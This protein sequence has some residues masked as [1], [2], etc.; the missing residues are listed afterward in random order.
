[1]LEAFITNCGTYASGDF[2]GEY[3]KFPATQKD[4]Q[5]LL[6]RIGVDGVLHEE[7]FITDYVTDIAGIARSLGEYE[8]IDELNYLAAL[9]DELD[10]D[11]M[12]VFEAAVE[13]GEH[14]GSVENLINLAQNLE[15]YRL[16]PDVTNEEELGYY[17]VD[18]MNVIEVPEYL[19]GYFDY[20][21][22][23]RDAH[24]N[25]GRFTHNGYMEYCGGFTEYYGG[26]DDLPGEHKIF[27]YPDPPEKMPIKD[28]LKMFGAMSTAPPTAERPAPERG[29]YR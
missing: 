2:R 3:L 27:A 4:V 1:V 11:D 19:A 18:E 14:A 22:Y 6:A 13:Y 21:A 20:E 7:I 12:K 8:S 16:S 29:E 26:R 5:N 28:Q 24:I 23:G 15:C 25:G 17:L 9:L 10:E